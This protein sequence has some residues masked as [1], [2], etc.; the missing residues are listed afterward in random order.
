MSWT[1]A[2][3]DLHVLHLAGCGHLDRQARK[4]DDMVHLDATTQED[5]EQLG[6][7]QQRDWIGNEAADLGPVELA[8]C[9][10]RKPRS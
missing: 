1:M 6:R 9:V 3:G 2:Y 4:G 7:W 8:P 5:A 10:N